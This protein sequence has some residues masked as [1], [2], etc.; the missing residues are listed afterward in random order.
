MAESR[1]KKGL[2]NAKVN[3]LFYFLSLGLS[4]FSRKTFLDNLGAEFIGLSGTLSNILS[5]LSLAEMGIGTAV[6]FNLY[7][8]IAENNRKRIND[9]ISVFGYLYN[10]IGI[11]IS[12]AACIIS[13][14]LPL[15][16]KDSNLPLGMIYFSFL[17]IVFS[18]LCGYFINY[19]QILLSADQKNYLVTKYIQS[20]ILVKLILQIVVA[21]YLQSCY[22]WI[23]L[24]I[25]SSVAVCFLLNWKI[26]KEYPWLRASIKHGKSVYPQNKQ[27]ITYTKQI[28]IHKIK[29]FLLSQ[30]DQ[31]LI[32][33]FVSLKMVAYYG[34]YTLIVSRI[35]RLFLTV[36]DGFSASVGNLVAEG[37]K[38]KIINVFWELFCINFSIASI[39]IFSLYHLLEPF[40]TL[41]L[42]KEYIL[43]QTILILL[44]VNTFIMEERKAVDLFNNAYGLYADTW[45]AWAEGIINISVTIIAALHWGIIGILL[46]KIIS[47]LCIVVLWKPYYLFKCGFKEKITIYWKGFASYGFVFTTTFLISHQIAINLPIIPTNF[48]SWTIYAICIVICFITSYSIGIYFICPGAK[49]LASRL[50]FMKRLYKR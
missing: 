28:F 6:A 45:S 48:I 49:S 7:K 18:S 42:G 1:V 9:L 10:K 12:I 5:F 13:I 22:L 37:N 44:L 25:I 31:I 21:H 26:N 4:F 17:S 43:G 19:R 38:E 41:W 11:F 40:I 27:I 8:P 35:T 24:E 2:L 36:I 20:S 29:D 32:F 30:S 14:F 16:F 39:L 3:L 33:A 23:T 34:N 50:T 46:G 47:L 15:I